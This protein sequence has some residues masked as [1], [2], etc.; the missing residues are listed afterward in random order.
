MIEICNAANGGREWRNA[1]RRDGA[2]D[3]VITLT[4]DGRIEG[5]VDGSRLGERRWRR[6]RLHFIH[7]LAD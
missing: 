7:F 1:P 2:A 4:V 6:T 3:L 5:D